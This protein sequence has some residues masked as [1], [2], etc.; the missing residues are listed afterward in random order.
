MTLLIHWFNSNIAY[1]FMTR[2]EKLEAINKRVGKKMAFEDGHMISVMLI[3]NI[4]DKLAKRKIIQAPWSVSPM[5]SSV[6][7]IC[8]EFEW[9][10]TDAEI[11]TFCKE[12]IPAEQ[13]D[14]F[15]YF[16]KASI[17]EQKSKTNG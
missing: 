11:Q 13:V 12:L 1:H 10:I 3:A 7:A 9:E 15:I 8:E 17:D 5:G 6:I 14:A 2:E 4:L 16:I